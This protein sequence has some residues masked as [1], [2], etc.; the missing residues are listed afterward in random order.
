MRSRLE[1]RS[2]T[3]KALSRPL[4]YWRRQ[5]AGAPAGLDL[6]TDF[7]RLEIQTFRGSV[8][9]ADLPAAL[10]AE[11]R[12]FSR[13]DGVTPFM[14]LLA[15]FDVLLARYSGQEDVLVG[16]P[17]AHRNI[18]VMRANLGAVSSFGELLREVR[19]AVLAAYEH[20]ELPF[21]TLVEQ[22]LPATGNGVGV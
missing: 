12:R 22:L 18:L 6:P 7:P 16:S 19:A 20:Q 10:T 8:R 4:D 2:A 14:L 21:E 11:L 9:A 13:R 17:G 15:A 3:A 5:L 1:P